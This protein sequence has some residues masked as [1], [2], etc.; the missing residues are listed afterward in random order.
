MRTVLHILFWLV[1]CL[2]FT[3]VAAPG[4]AA[5][6]AF[7]QLPEQGAMIPTY[8]DHF[9]NDPEGMGRLVAGYVTNPIFIASDMVQWFLAPTALLL[10]I[11]L[12]TPL[13]IASGPGQMICV[14]AL[15]GAL[16]LVVVQNA[17]MGPRLEENLQA[18]R[19]AAA[20]NRG[21]EA[22][23]AYA[24]FDADH[25]IAE[26]LFGIRL[27]LLTVAIAGAAG[28]TR[29]RPIEPAAGRVST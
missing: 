18:Y 26:P 22:A 11:L 12:R 9:A 13:K 5:I 28:G 7:T 24:A 17:F 21:E 2:W 16:G 3:M 15:A 29:T 23:T 8:A 19:D 10:A 4:I 20:A 27:L 1:T 14:L 25:R 6:S